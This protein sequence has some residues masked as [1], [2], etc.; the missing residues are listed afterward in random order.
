V[1]VG[2]GPRRVRPLAVQDAVK[3]LRASLVDGGL[4]HKTVGLVGPSE[5]T[6]DDAAR[7]VA[8][9][10]KKERLFVRA[11]LAFHY[12]LAWLAERTMTVPLVSHAQV[13]I[14]KEEVIEPVLA[15]DRVESGLVP[16]TAFDPDSIRAGL[17]ELGPFHLDDL[18]WPSMKDGRC[19]A[20]NR[21]TAR[22]PRLQAAS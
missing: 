22:R 14:L 4:S 19:G 17:P 16:S 1:F 7:R 3:V 8:A 12:L 21:T 13:R 9:V 6:F 15:P 18:R 5:L 10:V 11:P 2:I 20:R